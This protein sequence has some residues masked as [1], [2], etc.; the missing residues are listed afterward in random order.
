VGLIE[1]IASLGW[2]SKNPVRGGGAARVGSQRRGGGG[3]RW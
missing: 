3:G 1:V 2:G